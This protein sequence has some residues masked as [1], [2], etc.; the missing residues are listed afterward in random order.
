[1]R[2]T[3]P[4]GWA[5]LPAAGFQPAPTALTVGAPRKQMPPKGS[6]AEANQ[7]RFQ[8]HVRHTGAD[9]NRNNPSQNRIFVSW[10]IGILVMRKNGRTGVAEPELSVRDGLD[11]PELLRVLTAFKRGDFSARMPAV[12]VR[13]VGKIGDILNDVLELNERMTREF[14]RINRAFAEESKINRASIGVTW[15]AW[16]LRVSEQHA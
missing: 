8:Q 3:A 6:D 11:G 12:Q 7:K 15:R 13:L 4:V 5:I 9:K 10:Q 1:M 16:M 14:D 2:G